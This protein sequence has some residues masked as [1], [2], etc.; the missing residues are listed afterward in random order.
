MEKRTA[1]SEGGQGKSRTRTESLDLTRVLREDLKARMRVG[2]LEFI[3]E[4]FEEERREL[5]GPPWSRKVEGQAR[6]GGS[7]EG[8]IYLEGRRVPVTYPRILSSKGVNEHPI[9]GHV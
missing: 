1:G 4:L 5:I 9:V 6:S 2:M 8:S 7:E 3:E